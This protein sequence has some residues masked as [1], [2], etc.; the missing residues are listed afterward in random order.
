MYLI[1]RDFA[2]PFATIIAA[3][4]ASYVVFQFNSAQVQIARQTLVLDLFDRR[5]ALADELRSAIAS[6]T[7]TGKIL[8]DAYYQYVGAALRAS[9][10]FGPE[11]TD[12][13]ETVRAAMT[14]HVAVQD[15]AR[16]DNE[17]VCARAADAE[18]AAFTIIADFYKHFDPLIAPYMAMHQ[19]LP[20]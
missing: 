16:S 8:G 2:G 1:L 5:W 17:A 13:L 4:A 9:F 19:K 3:A 18:A 20:E 10:L 11:V 7:T 6:M 12:Y 15:A 14:R